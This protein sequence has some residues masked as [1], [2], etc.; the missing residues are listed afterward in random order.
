MSEILRP[1]FLELRASLHC[2]GT[3]WDSLL[4]ARKGFNTESSIDERINGRRMLGMLSS[5][6]S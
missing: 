1:L 5:I 6:S 2:G 4:L 3:G